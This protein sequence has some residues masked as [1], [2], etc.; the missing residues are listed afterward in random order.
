[1]LPSLLSVVAVA[2]GIINE[3][4]FYQRAG[5]GGE[6]DNP[7]VGFLFLGFPLASASIV[8]AVSA[9]LITSNES[10]ATRRVLILGSVAASLLCLFLVGESAFP[11]LSYRC[12]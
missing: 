11:D 7:V 3:Q 5:C 9:C 2:Y 10:A 1:M 4:W 6:D 8:L 12:R